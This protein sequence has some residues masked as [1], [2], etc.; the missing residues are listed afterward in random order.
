MTV[1]ATKGEP[2]KTLVPVFVSSYDDDFVYDVNYNN[3]SYDEYDLYEEY[4]KLYFENNYAKFFTDQMVDMILGNIEIRSDRKRTQKRIDRFLRDYKFMSHLRQV[5]VQAVVLGNGLYYVNPRKRIYRRVDASNYRIKIDPVTLERKFIF[6]PKVSITENRDLTNLIGKEYDSQAI[7]HLT[8]HEYAG[9]AYGISLYRSNIQDLKA[10]RKL[11]RD[12]YA[13]IT[14]LSS[15]DRIVKVD[16]SGVPVE[17]REEYMK[18]MRKQM[19]FLNTAV[20]TTTF[21]PKEHDIYY[22]GTSS[23]G[24]P[25]RIQPF[26]QVVETPLGLVM[27][28]FLIST[29]QLLPAGANKSIIQETEKK[30]RF[31]LN[32]YRN[33][34]KEFITEVLNA[35]GFDNFTIGIYDPILDPVQDREFS[36]RDVQ[37]GVITAEEYRKM[38]YPHLPDELPETKVQVEKKKE[39]EKV[40]IPKGNNMDGEDR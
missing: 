27:S 34:L 37:L 12:A 24:T 32:I 26:H 36:L 5:V 6:Y 20:Q 16:L 11:S 30:L 25:Q 14:H 7:K 22:G 31:M 28:M 18:N 4:E 13:A 38:Y 9:V 3:W 33:R 23:G 21:L 8:F 10:F 2:E 35:V 39:P 15:V 29:G 19:L 40:Y 1:K 17:E